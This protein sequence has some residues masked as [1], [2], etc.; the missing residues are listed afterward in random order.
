M[1]YPQTL[2][3]KTMKNKILALLAIATLTFTSC[4]KDENTTKPLTE[5]DILAENK[6]DAAIED[7]SDLVENQYLTQEAEAKRQTAPASFLPPCAVVTVNRT[8]TSYTR[9][10]DFGT[11]G[12]DLGN[13]N[14][15]RGKIIMHFSAD[16]NTLTTII[17][18]TFDDF[19]HN[20][21]HIVGN[22]TMTRI[23][24]NA[25]GNPERRF[26]V[27]MHITFANGGEYDRQGI[28][29]KEFTEGH[30]TW[31]LSD[32]VHVITGNST[33]SYPDGTVNSSDITT[34]I[35]RAFSCRFTA[36]GVIEFHRN[37]DVA[38]LDYGNGNCDNIADLTINGTTRQIR[39]F[40]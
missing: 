12:C 6:I 21:N 14:I 3:T 16:F 38:I 39:I 33:T 15:M 29:V 4:S 36:E 5:N 40:Y 10:V 37:S 26:E 13:G 18:Y 24:Q 32:N 17:S 9:T 28:R 1:P 27:D 31:T 2:K 20:N 8:F 23:R 25:N 30:D 19:Y 11:A 22:K 34:P 35:R 7:I